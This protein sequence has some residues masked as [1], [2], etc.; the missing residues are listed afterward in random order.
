MRGLGR[1]CTDQLCVT[2]TPWLNLSVPRFPYS[3]GDEHIQFMDL[4]EVEGEK[5]GAG[6][7]SPCRLQTCLLYDACMQLLLGTCICQTRW[8]M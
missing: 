8:G 3:N 7:C 6:L 2:W 1:G 5:V 4:L